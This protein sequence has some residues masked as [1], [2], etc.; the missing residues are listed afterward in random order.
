MRIKHNFE[1]L[2]F[3]RNDKQSQFLPLTHP[4]L[5]SEEDEGGL[6]LGLLFAAVRRKILLI[7]GITTATTVA[8]IVQALHSNPIYEA[9]FELLTKPI[10]VENKLVSSI[11]ESL[12]NQKDTKVVD[13]FDKTELRIL[14]SPK[15]MSPIVE[16]IEI[17]YP[18]SGL[19][20]IKLNIIPETNILEVSYQ[21]PDPKKLQFVLN[22]VS[23]AY[24]KY[25]LEERQ[26][27]VRQ[28][29]E[30]V[31]NQLPQLQQRV[32]ILQTQLQ[33]FRQKYHIIDPESQGKQLSNRL[34]NLAQQRVDNQV[35]LARSR[36]LYTTLQSQLNLQPNEVVTASTL[37]EGPRYQALLNKLQEIET[38]IAVQSAKYREESPT[39]QA[40]RE[41]RQKILP[42][43]EREAQ[44]ILS[45]KNSINSENTQGLTS[46]NSLRAG[47]T[48]QFFESARQIRALETKEKALAQAEVVL[49]EQLEQFPF[50]A[51]QNDDLGRKLKIAVDNLS[52][53]LSKREALRIDAAQ[54]QVPWQL[55]TPTTVPQPSTTSVRQSSVLGAALGL[56]LGIGVALLIDKLTNVV[57][58]SK[59]IKHITRLLILGAIP[60]NDRNDRFENLSKVAGIRGLTRGLASVFKL[61]KHGEWLRTNSNSQFQ[62][63]LSSLYTNIRFL[64]FDNPIRSLTIISAASGEGRSTV[65]LQLAQKAAA[66]GQRVLLVDADLR[67]P[68]I[69]MM[70]SLPNVKGLSNAIVEDENFNCL[71]HNIHSIPKKIEAKQAGEAVSKQ[72]VEFQSGGN[73]F[74]LTAGQIPPNPVNLLSSPQMQNLVKQFE[75]NF[76]LIIYDTSPL[77]ET[78]DSTLL[79]TYT[80]ASLLVVGLGKTSQYMLRALM[81][82]LKISATPILGVVINE[83]KN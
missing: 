56:F 10:T 30:F 79:A 58:S 24:L 47:Q 28:G 52:Q 64:N 36:T 42:L 49:R 41:Q 55:L 13:T 78:A 12:N 67:S 69:H 35:E 77:L 32:E 34:D 22:L 26:A 25:S 59:E 51:R 44:N 43:V 7:A 74:V 80:D 68:K 45:K 82:R 31:E 8:A 1:E 54:K 5:T 57:H 2:P 81:E 72:I 6:D 9:K 19:P 20:S 33:R 83:P 29:I 46:P 62:E 61:N 14:Q 21:D 15:L 50:L 18:N 53:F 73:L 60:F 75:A 48:Q 76:D 11:P 66:I 4:P 39:I 37:S 38:A 63:S 40:L 71:I 23:K 17:Q 16:Q 3:N 27:D 65:A 70:L